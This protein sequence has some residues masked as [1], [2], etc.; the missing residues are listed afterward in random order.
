MYYGRDRW[1]LNLLRGR[2]WGP[3]IVV[4]VGGRGGYRME[5]VHGLCVT[6]RRRGGTAWKVGR[7]DVVNGR[8]VRCTTVRGHDVNEFDD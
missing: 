2:T 1:T 6:G 7:H 3:V 5:E 8:E 4:R